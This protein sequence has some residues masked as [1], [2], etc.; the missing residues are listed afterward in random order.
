VTEGFVCARLTLIGLLVRHSLLEGSREAVPGHATNEPGK[1]ALSMH[2]A[3]QV[4]MYAAGTSVHL[5]NAT[6]IVGERSAIPRVKNVSL[7]PQVP[8]S[9]RIQLHFGAERLCEMS[10]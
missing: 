5:E 6:T 3:E 1:A 8:A 2:V 10:P 4:A 7:S 9:F